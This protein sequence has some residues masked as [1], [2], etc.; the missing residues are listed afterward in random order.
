MNSALMFSKASDEW[1]T[2]VETFNELNAEFGFD[3]DAASTRDKGWVDGGYF[4]PDNGF[5]ELRDAL[6]VPSWRIYGKAFWLN[7]PY[8]KCRQFIAKAAL[9]A[10]LGAT[11][12]CLVPSR[13]DTRLGHEHVWDARTNTYRPGVEV[14]FIKGR[15]KFGGSENSAPFPSAVIVFRPVA[16][17]DLTAG[18]R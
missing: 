5:P 17:S 1:E 16:S 18:V 10:S 12:V 6:A 3:H 13:T 4:G 9:E 14:R 8:S 7:P 11:V 2:P 15:L